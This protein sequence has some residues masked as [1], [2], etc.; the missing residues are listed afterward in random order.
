MEAGYLSYWGETYCG[1]LEQY[2]VGIEV[3]LQYWDGGGYVSIYNSCKDSTGRTAAY[4]YDSTDIF[5]QLKYAPSMVT[6]DSYR[7]WDWG[8]DENFNGTTWA[9]KY[10]SS[11]VT[12]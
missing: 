11:P 9:N 7:Y 1:S 8:Y 6:A 10:T 5:R 4:L 2:V 3:C 12:F